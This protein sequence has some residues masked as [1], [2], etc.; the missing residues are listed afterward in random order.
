MEK[1]YKTFESR[2]HNPVT[3]V[4][5]VV[6][7]GDSEEYVR[8]MAQ[9]AQFIPYEIVEYQTEDNIREMYRDWRK[10]NRNQK[11]NRV[12]VRMQWDDE[13]DEDNTRV[14]TIAIVPLKT[15][16]DT[17]ETPDDTWILF[18][19]SSL[20]GLLDLTKPNNGSEFTVLE[21]LEFWKYR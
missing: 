8:K 12:V 5:I 3:G 21:V 1:T 2:W 20:K 19:V 9:M 13:A 11:P 16:G 6:A 17:E 15:I 10:A 14:D 7:R 18:Y 4:D